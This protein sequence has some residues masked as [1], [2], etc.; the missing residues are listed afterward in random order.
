MIPI[1]LDVAWRGISDC[2]VCSIRDTVLFADLNKQDFRR[3]HTPIDDME[4][5][6]GAIVHSGGS[7]AQYLFTIRS[8]MV[9]V[10]ALSNEV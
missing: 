2:R 4:F 7:P 8:G 9:K 3:F 5:D 1:T 10:V 6:Q